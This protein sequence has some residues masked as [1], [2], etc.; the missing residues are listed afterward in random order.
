MSASYRY[1]R[2]KVLEA[3]RKGV[4]NGVNAVTLELQR[5]VG[6]QLNRHASNRSRGGIASA[7]GEPPGRATGTL[8]KSWQ[9]VAARDASRLGDPVRPKMSL[10]SG[11]R[12]ARIHE[13]GGVVTPKRSRFLPVPVHPDAKRAAAQGRG[14]KSFANTYVRRFG[15]GR[16]G[17]FRKGPAMGKN[18][19]RP[20]PLLYMLVRSVRIPKRPYLV[21]ALNAVRPRAVE[22]AGP[23]IRQALGGGR[24]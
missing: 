17:I 2:E 18:K 5:E 22:I 21:P 19:N 11:V 14:P 15:A 23:F 7:I 3:A 24:A 20:D 10:A 8:A 9:G 16:L 13:F 6:R 4:R 12:Y 1:N